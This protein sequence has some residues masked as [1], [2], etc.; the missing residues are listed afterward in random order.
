MIRVRI[1]LAVLLVAAAAPATT[2]GA[3]M[4]STLKIAKQELRL[5]GKGT[6][7]KYMISVYEAGLYLAQPIQQAKLILDVDEWM[8][9][10]IVINSKMV[11]Q[12]KLVDSLQKG[13]DN[14]TGGNTRS[15]QKEIDQFRGCFTDEITLG[16]TFDFVY[17]P[18]HGVV[19]LKNGQQK[20]RIAGMQFKQALFGIWLGERP[21]D[22]GLKVALLGTGTRR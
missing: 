5:N 17:A 7:S 20:G 18:S 22:A 10:R 15:I 21:A 3:E 6:R 11:S 19:V 16:D 12:Q 14:S 8:A 1:S 13:F 2:Y 9:I 4:P